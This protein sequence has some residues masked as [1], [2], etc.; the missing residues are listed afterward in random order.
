MKQCIMTLQ[1]HQRSL[2]LAPI[3]SMCVTSYRL[4]TVLVLSCFVSEILELLYAAA[5]FIASHGKTKQPDKKTKAFQLRLLRSMSEA[6]YTVVYCSSMSYCHVF[7]YIIFMQQ[8]T[9]QTMLT[10]MY[11]TSCMIL[12]LII[13]QNVT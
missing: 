8:K 1:G 5:F 3:E 13:I 12:Y 7:L 11:C 4:S 9:M 6:D 2:I 10:E